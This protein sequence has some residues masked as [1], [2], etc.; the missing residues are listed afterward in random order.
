MWLLRR[1]AWRAVATGISITLAL[2]VLLIAPYWAGPAIFRAMLD[3]GRY[4]T[5]TLASLVVRALTPA[6]GGDPARLLIG[7]TVRVA[8]LLALG[9][10]LSRDGRSQTRLIRVLAWSHALPVTVLC[11]WY[12]P[13]YATW[14]LLFAAML[15]RDRTLGAVASSLTAGA[16]LVRVRTKFVAAISDGGGGDLMVEALAAAL[17]LAPV[18]AALAVA[19]ARP[20]RGRGGGTAIRSAA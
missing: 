9:V 19:A 12:Q 6:I 7:G 17:A 10:M 14:P 18:G 15:P 3:E 11:A 4:F 8:L 16:L 5:G 20:R 13:W 2:A 1:R